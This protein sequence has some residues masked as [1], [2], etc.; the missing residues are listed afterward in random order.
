MHCIDFGSAHNP[1]LNLAREEHLF[2]RLKT[3]G[4]LLLFYVNTEAVIIGRNQVP[5]AEVP[6]AG[7]APLEL[8]LVRRL[9]GGGAVYHDPGNLNYS[10]LLRA[11]APGRPAAAAIL[12]PVVRALQALGLPARLAAHNAILVGRYKVSGTA[13]YMNPGKIMTHG[14]LLVDADL[15]RLARVLTPDS[16]YRVHTRGRSSV[17]SPVVN[18]RAL[19]PHIAAADLRQALRRSF[20]QTFGPMAAG[21]LDPEDDRAAR[22]LAADKYQTWQWNSGRSPNCMLEWEGD[23]RGEVCR[24]R[25]TVS[26]GVITAVE[27][28]APAARQDRFQRWAAGWLEGQRLGDFPPVADRRNTGSQIAETAPVEFRRWLWAHLPGPLPLP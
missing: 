1:A 7:Q 10:I 22:A 6:A 27:V 26:R 16:A 3:S 25:L 20:A 17:R 2:R 15:A 5:W 21:T 14:T 12:Q 28:I 9:S 8:P 13:Q 11:T 4:D 19:R 23:Y 24:G 18:L